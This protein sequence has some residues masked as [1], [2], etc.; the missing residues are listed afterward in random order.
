MAGPSLY[1]TPTIT[2]EGAWQ[3]IAT[4]VTTGTVE[5]LKSNYK[6]YLAFEFT[7]DPAP[8]DAL[9]TYRHI[10]QEETIE[11][12]SFDSSV[13]VYIYLVGSDSDTT[14]TNITNSIRIT[15]S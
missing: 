8:T 13:D 9:A 14:E 5:R 10:F 3:K 1:D 7:L 6:F 15:T 11:E 12:F 2:T 4:G